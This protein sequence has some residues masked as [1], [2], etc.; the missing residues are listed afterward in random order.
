MDTWVVSRLRFTDSAEV[1]RHVN[2]YLIFL[3]LSLWESFLEM[4]LLGQQVKYMCNFTRSKISNAWW[5][6]KSSKADFLFP[7][8]K[9]DPKK[10]ELY[11][12]GWAPC[13]TGFPC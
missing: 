7:H 8:M 13:S 2:A 1:N 10:L 12:G 9:G 11:S 6:I 4:E 5:L 3:R